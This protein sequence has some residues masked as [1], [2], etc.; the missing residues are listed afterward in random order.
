MF[1][2]L[3]ASVAFRLGGEREENLSESPGSACADL[4]RLLYPAAPPLKGSDV[5]ELQERLKELGYYSGPLDGLYDRKTVDAVTQMQRQKGLKADGCVSSSTWL[6]LSPPVMTNQ[7]AE[8][9]KPPSAPVGVIT[10]VVELDKNTLSVLIDGNVYKTYPVATGKRDTPS[11]VGEWRIVDKQKHWGDGFGSRWLG[12]NVPWGIYGIH[13][14]N[15]PWSV[16]KSVSGGCFRM[17]NRD[18]EELFEWIP[19]RTVVRVI[20]SQKVKLS[21]SAYKI[22]MTGQEVA[23]IQFRLQEKGF[24]PGLADGRFGAEMEK[25]V[26]NFQKQQQISETGVIDEATLRLLDFQ[27][28]KK[29]GT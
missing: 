9:R 5:A 25:A 12:F 13:G 15:K 7:P 27:V 23:R 8:P 17:H 19:L 3:L 29:E 14:T 18:V 4:D 21:K 28:E 6:A 24:S 1:L 11:P 20:D 26:R 2:V 10:L 16:G 22:G